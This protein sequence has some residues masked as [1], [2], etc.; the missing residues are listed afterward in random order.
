[1]ALYEYAPFLGYEKCE[2]IDRTLPVAEGFFLENPYSLVAMLREQEGLLSFDEIDRNIPLPTFERRKQE[3][4]CL[5][6]DVLSNNEDSG[7]SWMPYE[8]LN[9]RVLFR[10]QRNKHPLFKGSALPYVVANSDL[11]YFDPE[12][13]LVSLQETRHREWIIYN[14][15]KEA[16]GSA[17]RFV[18]FRPRDVTHLLSGEQLS[19]AENVVK[20][21]GNISMLLGGPGTGKTTSLKSIVVGMNEA[22]PNEEIAILTPTGRAAKRVMETFG[23]MD[24]NVSTMHAFVDYGNPRVSKKKTEAKVRAVGLILVD[25]SSMIDIDVL[26][27]LIHMV[28]FSYTKMIFVGDPDQLEAVKAGDILS[29]MR[30]MN[31]YTEYLTRN[32][33]SDGTLVENSQRIKNHNIFPLPGRDFKIVDC[34]PE[35]AKA[36][37]ARRNEADRGML[38]VP[39]R[40]E[41]YAGNIH[42]LNDLIQQKK[43]GTTREVGGK[44]CIGDC[45]IFTQTNYKKHYFNGEI[46]YLVGY[47]RQQDAYVVQVDDIVPYQVLVTE[48]SDIELGYAIT[49]TKSQGSEAGNVDIYIPK[50]SPFLTSSLLY[51]AVT[52]AKCQVTLW[53]P[54]EVY[55]KIVLNPPKKR[56]TMIHVWQQGA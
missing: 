28:D 55:I 19:C 27:Q 22:Y 30:E 15:V 26:S 56:R 42:E 40:K 11:F 53:I 48:D 32:Y 16:M 3:M 12:K 51:T 37:I 17:C 33:R 5:I 43:Y 45:V 2:E 44:Y 21:G 1:M 50:F 31:V 8:E 6:A 18:N 29:D 35:I 4:R 47:D 23:S 24:V 14:K 9:E 7:H 13:Q 36:L 54:R 38:I 52:R 25:E 39:Y 34:P 41:E 46:G 20:C 10:L 49:V